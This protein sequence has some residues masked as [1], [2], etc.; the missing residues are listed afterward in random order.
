[1]IS[2]ITRDLSSK[3][4]QKKSNEIDKFLKLQADLNLIFKS[5]YEANV[6]NYFDYVS[7]LSEKII[8]KY[9]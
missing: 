9:N 2:F 5:G 3:D 1:M 7:W 6:L 8:V 4:S